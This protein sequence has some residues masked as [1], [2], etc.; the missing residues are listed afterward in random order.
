MITPP[1]ADLSDT[2]VCMADEVVSVIKIDGGAWVWIVQPDTGAFFQGGSHYRS[3]VAA[4][5][6]GREFA[7]QLR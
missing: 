4:L 7:S 1:P 6:A 2:I 3:K 5:K